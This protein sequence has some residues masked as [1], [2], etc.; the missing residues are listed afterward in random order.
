MIIS[1]KTAKNNYNGGVFFM[2]LKLINKKIFIILISVAICAGT[3]YWYYIVKF[4]KGGDING[5]T[6]IKGLLSFRKGGVL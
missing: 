3:I 5:A 6:F 1:A 4:K 2:L